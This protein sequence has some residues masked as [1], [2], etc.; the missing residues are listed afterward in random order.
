[1][2]VSRKLILEITYKVNVMCVRFVLRIIGFGA[3]MLPEP[4]VA[5]HTSCVYFRTP[6][7]GLQYYT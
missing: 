2:V 6:L 1:M 4:S 5:N 3:W 7:H